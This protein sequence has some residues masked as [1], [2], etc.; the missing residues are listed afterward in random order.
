MPDD[1]DLTSRLLA[2]VHAQSEDA[3]VMKD[4]VDMIYR[5]RMVIGRQAEEIRLSREIIEKM[6]LARDLKAG[7][8]A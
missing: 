4:A 2:R 8:T 1:D 7:A 6:L 3:E 5:L